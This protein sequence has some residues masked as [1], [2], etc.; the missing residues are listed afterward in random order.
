MSTDTAAELQNF[1][2]EATRKLDN[3]SYKTGPDY[4]LLKWGSIKG[5]EL[6]SEKGKALSTEYLEHGRSLS[7]MAQKDD[8]RQ[9]EIIL[10]MIDECNGVI[11]S[12]WDGL[13]LHKGASS[14]VYHWIW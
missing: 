4:I 7:A 6:T 12:D 14:R 10:E 2:K 9:K 5:W 8:E 1:V 3:M 11:Q 13:L